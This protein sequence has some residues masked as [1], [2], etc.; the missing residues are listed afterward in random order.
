LFEAFEAALDRARAEWIAL[1]AKLWV[2]HPAFMRM[3]V[4]AHR[5]Q[6]SC[7]EW[8]G[9][10]I[11]LPQAQRLAVFVLPAGKLG[12]RMNADKRG[13]LGCLF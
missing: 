10:F 7:V 11:D 9:D 6:A 5:G 2:L 3:K 12:T 1:F 4:L 13:F 8:R